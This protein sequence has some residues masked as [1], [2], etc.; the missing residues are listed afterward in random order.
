[1]PTL[2]L[3]LAVSVAVLVPQRALPQLERRAFETPHSH[4]RA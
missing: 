4:D 3:R 2:K 1:V